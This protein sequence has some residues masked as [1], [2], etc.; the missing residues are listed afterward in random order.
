MQPIVSGQGLI[1][2]V[3]SIIWVP[4]KEMNALLPRLTLFA[5][6]DL[7]GMDQKARGGDNDYTVLVRG[8]LQHRWKTLH[9][10][11]SFVR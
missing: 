6:L 11:D 3:D 7:A 2:D 5:A 1:D 8:R 10:G 4:R 9:T